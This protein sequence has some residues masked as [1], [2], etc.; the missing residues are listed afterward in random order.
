M[1]TISRPSFDQ[2]NKEIVPF[3]KDGAI[4]KSNP[5]ISQTPWDS[6]DTSARSKTPVNSE[7]FPFKLPC[8]TAKERTGVEGAQEALSYDFMMISN[9]RDDKN[10]L[11][12]APPANTSYFVL[13]GTKGVEA[14]WMYARFSPPLPGLHT[15]GTST[16]RLHVL[17]EYAQSNIPIFQTP[18]DPEVRYTV[19]FWAI[20]S[21]LNGLVLPNNVGFSSMTFYSSLW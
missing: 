2:V 19:E 4:D 15:D 6:L 7:C 10:R 5:V 16:V 11:I 14:L 3:I 21:R 20:R 1:L 18:L 17:S 13:N 9:W 8:Q 12:I